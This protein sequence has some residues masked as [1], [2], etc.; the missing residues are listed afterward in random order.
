[1]NLFDLVLTDDDRQEI[2]VLHRNGRR[3]PN[4]DEFSWIP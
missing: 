2:S 3:G 1:V 4:P